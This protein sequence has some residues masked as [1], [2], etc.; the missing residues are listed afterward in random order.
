MFAYQGHHII[1][2]LREVLR[3]FVLMILYFVVVWSAA[4]SFMYDLTRKDVARRRTGIF[5]YEMAVMRAFSA[6]S[7]N[8]VSLPVTSVHS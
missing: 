2:N 3:V 4:F 7:S 1:H 8:F 6:R 5:D